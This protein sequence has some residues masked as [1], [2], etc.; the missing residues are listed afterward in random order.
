MVHLGEEA[1]RDVLTHKGLLDQRLDNE[2]AQ[3]CKTAHVNAA[4]ML[5][6]FLSTL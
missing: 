5:N 4:M 2:L 6:T 1:I 3:V